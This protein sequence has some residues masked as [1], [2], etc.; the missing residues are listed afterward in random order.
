MG[1]FIDGPGTGRVDRAE[2]VFRDEDV[3]GDLVEIGGGGLLASGRDTFA[4]KVAET[5]GDEGDVAVEVAGLVAEAVGGAHDINP[6]RQRKGG[7]IAALDDFFRGVEA[8]PYAA[9]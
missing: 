1:G 4:G 7:A 6:D 3:G 2:V 5:G 8:D 9:C